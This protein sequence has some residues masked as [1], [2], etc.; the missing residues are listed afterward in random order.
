MYASTT[1]SCSIDIIA[2]ERNIEILIRLQI[3]H[4]LAVSW[5]YVLEKLCSTLR[6]DIYSEIH[7][8]IP[9]RCNSISKFYY[10]LLI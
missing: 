2:F 4:V 1:L 3:V 9:T 7:E 8:E 10:S 6:D 5:Y